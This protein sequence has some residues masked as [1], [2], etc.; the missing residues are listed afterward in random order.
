MTLTRRRLAVPR[1]RVLLQAAGLLL[2]LLLA[3]ASLA[4]RNAVLAAQELEQA[5]TGLQEARAAELDIATASAALQNAELLLVSA[6]DRLSSPSVSMVAAVPVVGRTL[7]AERAVVRAANSAFAGVR[8]ALDAAPELRTPEGVNVQ[9]LSDLGARL[10]PAADRASRDLDRLRNIPLGLTPQPVRVAVSDTVT[11]LVPVVAG[12]R[13]GADGAHLASSLLGGD[14]P[15][16]VLVALQNNAEL[17]GTGGYVS[18]FATGRLDGGRLQLDPFRD[19]VDVSDRPAQAR[20]VPAPPEYVE[21]FGPFLADTTLWR[22]WTMSPDVPDA[23]S[24]SAEVAAV[25]LNE[26]PDVVVLLDVPALAAIVGLVGRDVALPGGAT[27][28]PDQLAQALF[29]DT[30]ASA[31]ADEVEQVRRRSDLQAAAGATVTQLLTD[32]ANPVTAAQELARLARGRHVAVWST[33][34]SEQ[35]QLELLGIAGSA[36]P[37]GDDLALIS[38]NNLNANKLDYYVDRAVAVEAT[39]G[40]NSAE[41]VQRVVLDNRAPADLVPYVAGSDTPGTVVERVEFSVSAQAQFR[42]LRENGR[43]TTGDVR[44]GSERTRVHTFVTLPRGAKVE[45]EL[46]YAVP[47]TDGHYRALLVPQALAH[48]ATLDVV[49]QPAGG[50]QLSDVHGAELADG[51]AVRRGQWAEQELLDVH[52]HAPGG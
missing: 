8:I 43:P 27:V 25:L 21:D 10:R 24:V 31:G 28:T 4:G 1:R 36:D 32:E 39:V 19:I 47:V 45:V 29:V 11:T 48:D 33:H 35:R 6:E 52:A 37:Q 30:Y 12:L 5:R 38:I 34:E 50:L 18:T 17:R 14:G 23:A 20:R 40:T 22:E 46:R 3:M 44:A 42:S 7:D 13:S 9:A 51:R 15:R 26:R 41:V 2:L 49:V 16:R